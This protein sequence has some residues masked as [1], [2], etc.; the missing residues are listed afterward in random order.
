[1]YHVLL[2]YFYNHVENVDLEVKS[3]KEFC[4]KNNILGRVYITSE[5]ING[6]VSGLEKDIKNYKA[7]LETHPIF[8]GIVFKE[9]VHETHTFKKIIVKNKNELVNLSL[10]DDVN[11]KEITGRYIE[12]VEFY[13][14]V[15]DKDTVIIDARND[16]EY[17]MGHFKGA[18]RPNIRAFRELPDW[19]RANKEKLEGKKIIAYCTGGVRCEK[20]TG[21]LKK[22]GYQD[23]GQLHGGIQTYGANEETKGEFWEGSMYVF[24][25][26]I[27]MP[28]NQVN[29]VIV[30]K[31]HYS[32]EPCDRMFNCANPDCNEQIFGSSENEHAHIGGCSLFCSMHPLNR[33]A[34]K[35]DRDELER[36]KENLLKVPFY[37]DL[38]K[39]TPKEEARI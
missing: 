22:E 7:Y 2:Y 11:P 4:K 5:G 8:K 17:D 12:P 36:L 14:R 25:E 37:F 26:R 34:K 32:H 13:Q 24:D 23:V 9:S 19:V 1:M 27:G 18:L 3:H 30:S 6:T 38:T 35:M 31:D 10:E 15:H 21:W 29:P 20:F 33:Y 16:Y 39:M 28:I